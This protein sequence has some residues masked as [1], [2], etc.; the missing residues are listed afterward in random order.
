MVHSVPVVNNSVLRLPS[1]T[2]ARRPPLAVTPAPRASPPP[3]RRQAPRP[4]R[5]ARRSARS[6]PAA[7]RGELL[8]L[9]RFGGRGEDEAVDLAHA[10]MDH[11]KT[12]AGDL[13]VEAARQRGHPA[14]SVTVEAAFG[15]GVPFDGQAIAS[16]ALGI[17][18]TAI[19]GAVAERLLAIPHHPPDA[20]APYRHQPPPDAPPIA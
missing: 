19:P 4:A 20:A 14:P 3:G 17:T 6:P 10:A 12:A 11:G 18:A 1:P 7:R 9:H 13:D 2:A 8:A 16:A 5:L 15:M